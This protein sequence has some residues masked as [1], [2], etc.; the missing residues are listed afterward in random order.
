[1]DQRDKALTARRKTGAVNSGQCRKNGPALANLLSVSPWLNRL[2]A[3][4]IEVSEA[5][6]VRARAKLEAQY[7]DQPAP[8]IPSDQQCP[9]CGGVGAVKVAPDAQPG[10]VNFGKVAVCPDK[11]HSDIRLK[12]LVKISRLSVKE[13]KIRLSNCKEYH[14]ENEHY[15][16][17][18]Y[19]DVYPSN[20]EMLSKFHALAQEPLQDNKGGL[21]VWGPWGSGKTYAAMG[22]VN[23]INLAGKG[24]AVYITMSDL[25]D[26]LKAAYDPRNQNDKEFGGWSFDRRYKEVKNT[27]VIVLD[28]FDFDGGKVQE[29]YHNL[30]LI[31]KYIYDRYR[32]GIDGL[33]M[34]IFISNSPIKALQQ[35]NIVSR[36]N[37]WRFA[38]VLNTAPDWRRKSERRKCRL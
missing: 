16:L 7:D 23:E 31:S 19:G 2:R 11:F 3:A 38:E 12:R 4:G 26:F 28:E 24:P 9:T 29:T 30:F 36:L 20:R 35:G 21:Y 6:L 22:L 8:V 34:T 1:M 27:Q 15:I 14:N 13:A 32:T 5:D 10:Q 25:L 33:T 37:D 17:E 18:E